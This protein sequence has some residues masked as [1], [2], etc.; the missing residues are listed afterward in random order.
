M[1]LAQNKN[2][3]VIHVGVEEYY[4]D[5]RRLVRGAVKP[6]I[7]HFGHFEC[8]FCLAKLNDCNVSR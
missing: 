8:I 6:L 3:N 7:A 4:E 2:K 5:F 1:V